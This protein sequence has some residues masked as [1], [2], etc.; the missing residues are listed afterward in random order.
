MFSFIAPP[1][2]LW[3]KWCC[4]LAVQDLNERL[5]E[6]N[7]EGSVYDGIYSTIH[8]A[9]PSESVIHLSSNLAFCA[10]GVQDMCNEKRQPTYDEYTWGD[11]RKKWSVRKR[12]LERNV[13]KKEALILESQ[14]WVTYGGVALSGIRIRMVSLSYITVWLVFKFCFRSYRKETLHIKINWANTH[15]VLVWCLFNSNSIYL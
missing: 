15:F 10:V 11:M 12:Q 2:V 14:I 8:V 5:S 9:K 13:T 6:L 7:I 3:D 4:S 1:S